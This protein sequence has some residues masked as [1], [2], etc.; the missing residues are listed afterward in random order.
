MSRI[1]TEIL[2]EINTDYKN[3]EKYIKQK[4]A[5]TII[6]QHAYM[7]EKKFILPDGDPPY[8]PAPQPLGMTQA[9]LRNEVKRLYIFTKFGGNI[10][11]MRREQLY[12][13]LLEQVHPTEA[14]LLNAM[15]DQK[16]DALYPKITADFVKKNFPDVLPEGTVVAEHQAP[17]ILDLPAPT[18]PADVYATPWLTPGATPVEP[19]PTVTFG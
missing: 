6:F 14:K 12:V 4:P 5:L 2:K 15:K 19:T 7:K 13:Q 16:L 11:R 9:A 3:A 18:K 1:I 8:K 10:T 17:T